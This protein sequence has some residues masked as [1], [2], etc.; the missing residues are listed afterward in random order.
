M[1]SR[2]EQPKQPDPTGIQCKAIR[3]YLNRPA[4]ANIKWVWCVPTSARIAHGAV[5]ASGSRSGEIV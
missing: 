1:V 5:S 2:W 4:N 3:D